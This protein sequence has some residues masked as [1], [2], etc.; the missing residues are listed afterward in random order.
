MT[1]MALAALTG[2]CDAETGPD[3]PEQAGGIVAAAED[4]VREIRAE[5]DAEAILDEIV[6]AEGASV[7]FV[8]EQVSIEDGGVGM[9]ARGMPRFADAVRALELTPLELY[10]ALAPEKEAPARLWEDHDQAVEL[11]GRESRAPRA[12]RLEQGRWRRPGTRSRRG[13]RSRCSRCGTARSTS[14]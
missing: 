5:A 6:L 7:R 10:L 13:L 14:P 2:A 1:L 11:Q 12:F 9:L 4:E 8:D 3:A